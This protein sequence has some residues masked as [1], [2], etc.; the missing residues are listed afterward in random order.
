MKHLDIK[1]S[2]NL[3]KLAFKLRNK[4]DIY[5]VG[6]YVRNH[7]L[8][9]CET[10]VDL[11]SKLTP[12][13]LKDYLKYT[14]FKVI[15]KNKGLGSVVIQIG[16]EKYEH[17]TFRTEI[18]EDSGKHTPEQTF[19][20]EDLRDDAKR[21]DFTC[22]CIYYNITKKRF[23]DIYS[24]A[25]DVS[26]NKLK[27]IETP[28]FVFKNDGLRILRMI[29]QS[30]ELNFS[31]DKNT[32]SMA[33]AM[34]YRLKEISGVR[35]LNELKL[36]LYADQKYSYSDKNAYLRAINMLNELKLFSHFYIPCNKIKLDLLKKVNT[37]D[38]FIALLIDIVNAVNPDC[39]EYFLKDLLGNKGLC[40]G[41]K[42][43]DEY[44]NIVCG[45]F[46]ALNKRNNKEYFFKYFENFIVIREFLKYTNKKLFEKYNF[47]YNYIVLHHIP[48]RVKDLNI[49]GNDIKKHL[50]DFD[51]K[52]ISKL[53]K[54]LLEEVFENEIQNVKT[55]LIKEA[56]RLASFR[57]C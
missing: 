1:I 9:F 11:S 19:F 29:R 25:Y 22:N 30:C 10:D 39:V 15:D 5:I 45:Y 49:T 36:M 55:N 12:E 31:I 37:E 38:R 23:I 24:G 26:K 50:P 20:V 4:A 51:E 47:Y 13:Q 40:L 43:R 35:K 44:V 54:Q 8:G 6:G 32:F 2:E 46:D 34:S 17:T 33:K 48:I 28:E 3:E 42:L 52:K 7:F 56:K 57:D 14:G 53:L 27:C 16:N 18:Y 41:N 21:R